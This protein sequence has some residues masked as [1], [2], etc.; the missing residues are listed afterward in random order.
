MQIKVDGK[1]VES[2]L[3]HLATQ[4]FPATRL[5]EDTL[6]VLF[7]ASPA[8]FAA[9]VELD[10]WLAKSGAD[11]GLRVETIVTKSGG[12]CDH[13]FTRELPSKQPRRPA[14]KRFRNTTQVP[15]DMEH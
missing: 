6:E 10:D 2:L 13:S 1:H 14:S 9:A 7:P 12:G 8:C 4:G 3:A 5:G 11:A 15:A